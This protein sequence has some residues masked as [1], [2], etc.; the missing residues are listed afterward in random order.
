MLGMCLSFNVCFD[1]S[2]GWPLLLKI[3]KSMKRGL[4][5]QILE[6]KKVDVEAGLWV[7]VPGDGIW[8]DAVLDGVR[9]LA[10]GDFLVVRVEILVLEGRGGGL[11]GCVGL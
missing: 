8:L 9:G 5:A 7:A 10:W 1:L 6:R 2:G 11:R 3:L 4:I